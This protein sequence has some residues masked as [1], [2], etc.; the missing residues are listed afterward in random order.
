MRAEVVLMG[1][2]VYDQQKN[3][4]YSF[5]YQPDVIN[6][7]A[8]Y[9]DPNYVWGGHTNTGAYT[10]EKRGFNSTPFENCPGYIRY[11]YSEFE[12]INRNIRLQRTQ[13]LAGSLGGSVYPTVAL[14]FQVGRNNLMGMIVFP[15]KSW[16]SFKGEFYASLNFF[17]HPL[18]NR[19]PQLDPSFKLGCKPPRSSQI[20]ALDLCPLERECTQKLEQLKNH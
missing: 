20:E 8:Y 2:A 15:D 10:C 14:I 9:N 4:E 1:F 17:L 6:E 18:D 19:Y 16:T 3:V 13:K 11:Q 7:L 5:G 12:G